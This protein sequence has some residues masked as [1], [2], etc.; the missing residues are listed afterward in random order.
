MNLSTPGTKRDQFTSAFITCIKRIEARYD[1]AD[2][3]GGVPNT[4]P[5]CNYS[6]YDECGDPFD[7]EN[8]ANW[9]GDQ[10]VGFRD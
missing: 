1:P 9:D 10:Q 4:S 5:V 2:H 8:G 3:E 7:P 6:Y